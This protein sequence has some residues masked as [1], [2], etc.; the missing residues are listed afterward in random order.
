M[1]K[2]SRPVSIGVLSTFPDRERTVTAGL[3]INR[4]TEFDVHRNRFNAITQSAGFNFVTV[5]VTDRIPSFPAWSGNVT[6]GAGP[7]SELPRA[8]SKAS[9]IT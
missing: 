8:I 3:T 2:M 6:W 4:F 9:F 1:P 5:S 7:T